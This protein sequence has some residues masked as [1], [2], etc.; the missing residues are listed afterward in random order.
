MVLFRKL[1][2]IT[3]A[4]LLGGVPAHTAW[5]PP[6]EEG[7]KRSAERLRRPCFST[8]VPGTFGDPGNAREHRPFS[9]CCWWGAML[10]AGL[11]YFRWERESSSDA[12][13]VSDS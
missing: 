12:A 8:A 13:E 9:W 1:S 4:F 3:P 7:E 2:A 5:C 6:L 11:I 10:L